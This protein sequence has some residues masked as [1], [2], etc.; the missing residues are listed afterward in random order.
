[1]PVENAIVKPLPLPPGLEPQPA[2]VAPNDLE[3]FADELPTL[4]VVDLTGGPNHVRCR[5]TLRNKLVQVHCKLGLTTPVWSYDVLDE[6]SGQWLAPDRYL[7]PTLVVRKGQRVEV[8]YVNELHGVLPVRVLVTTLGSADKNVDPLTANLPGNQLGGPAG[9]AT[10]DTLPGSQ[11]L[12]AWTVTHLHGGRTAAMYDGWTENAMLPPRTEDS[13]EK[14]KL[15]G[16]NQV[17][18]YENNQRATLLWYH[19]HGMGIT[20]LNVVAGLAGAYLIRDPEEDRALAARNIFLPSGAHEVFLIIQDRNLDTDANGKLNGRLLH[21]TS[22]GTKEFFA[23]YT[24]VNGVIWPRKD[25]ERAPYRL[26]LL[27]GSNARTYC[28][29]MVGYDAKGKRIDLALNDFVR[30]IGSDGGLLAAPVKLPDNTPPQALPNSPAPPDIPPATDGLLLAPAERA[31]LYVD[32]GVLPDEVDHVEVV[33]TAFAPFHRN[34]VDHPNG[35][36]DPHQNPIPTKSPGEPQEL[37]RLPYP[38][39]MRFDLGARTKSP[40]GVDLLGPTPPQL[41]GPND[42]LPS[43]LSDLPQG[44]D[45]P[46]P[47]LVIL[48]EDPGGMLMM[49]EMAKNTPDVQAKF[50][51][52]LTTTAINLQDTSGTTTYVPVATRFEDR[53]AFFP[54]YGCWDVWQVLNLST[55]THPFHI[56]LVQFRALQRQPVTSNITNP[57]GSTT[58]QPF[59]FPVPSG[60]TVPTVTIENPLAMDANEQGWK[61]TVRVNP[62]ELL[63]FAAKFEGFTSRYMYHCHILEHEDHEMMRPFVVLPREVMTVTPDMPMLDGTDVMK[64]DGMGGMAGM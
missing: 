40:S 33:N 2:A 52:L 3:P 34:T 1:M 9:G 10:I 30:Q 61:D 5:V 58:W 48:V 37:L 31:D 23:P 39:V 43:S 46:K 29:K 26:R 15:S 49:F 27:N 54:R 17:A 63:T 32:F 12:Y 35:E 53:V 20:R 13:A 60:G 62:G 8:M 41:C 16:Q 59:A 11:D 42:F 25:V 51:P 19:D 38:Q 21:K 14:I 6:Q 22:D 45:R 44:Q 18:I 36:Q 50:S 4:P 55:D 57:D 28:L 56:H 64:M 24:L 47:R 7:G